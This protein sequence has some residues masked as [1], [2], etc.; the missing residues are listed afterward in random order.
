MYLQ[1]FLSP[2][3][4]LCRKL[5]T[6]KGKAQFIIIMLRFLI[7]LTWARRLTCTGTNAPGS[8]KEREHFF[9]PL[10]GSISLYCWEANEPFLC[11]SNLSRWTASCRTPRETLRDKMG[12]PSTQLLLLAI[13]KLYLV[14]SNTI[15]E[16]IKLINPAP[17]SWCLCLNFPLTHLHG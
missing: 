4:T 12:P 6:F 10:N 1:S 8:I 11:S 15:L 14:V 17:C 2:S 5:K 16:V 9:T 7:E 3:S 13:S